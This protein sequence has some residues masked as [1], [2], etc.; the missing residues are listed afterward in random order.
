MIKMCGVALICAVSAYLLKRLKSELSFAVGIVAT[1]IFFGYSL[2]FVEPVISE[3]S[4]FLSIGEVSD[5]YIP[6]IKSLGVAVIVQIVSGVCDDC[7]EG[8]I[9]DGVVLAGKFEMLYICF[10]LIKKI[11][12]YAIELISLE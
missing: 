8:R 10:P 5:Y 7:G 3:I 4:V 12:G 2:G 11:L 1:L 9:S 6:I